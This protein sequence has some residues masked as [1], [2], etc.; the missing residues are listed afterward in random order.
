M[1]NKISI[2]SIVT[3]LILLFSATAQAQVLPN[4]GIKA[5]LNYSTFNNS[6]GSEYKAGFLGGVYAN[7]NVPGTPMAIQPE[8][9]YAQY[10]AND[11]NS[12]AKLSV[13]YIQIPVLAKFGFG[14]PGVPV[15]PEVF[16][17]PYA[18]FNINS[19]IEDSNLSVDADEFF[20]N[21]DWGVVVGAGVQ[22][23]K[24]NFELRY[25]AGL[26]DVFE[27]QYADGEKNGALALT[28][29]ISF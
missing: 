16:F 4:I 11:E 29:G 22:L 3:G 27:D 9:L 15:R 12:D 19:E 24:L 1:K 14:A 23:S 2:L 17:G 10:G 6:D 21:S 26:T 20:K 25:T 28:V 8:I 7:I 5:G 13:D 18:G